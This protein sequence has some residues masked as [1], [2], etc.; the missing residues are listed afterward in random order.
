M[1]FWVKVIKTPDAVLVNVCDEDLLGKV[2][3][4]GDVVL[5]I[6]KGFYGGELVDEERVV[7]IIR[8]GDIVSLVGRYIIRLVSERYGNLER[9]VKYVRDVPYVNL[10]YD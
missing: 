7:E 8:Q 1:K 9:F 3:R 5:R 4:E 6:T 2:F 10:L